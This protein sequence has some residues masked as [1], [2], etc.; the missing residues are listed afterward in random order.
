MKVSSI[1]V[2]CMILA[3]IM[4][5]ASANPTWSVDYDSG[6]E[7][8][9]FLDSLRK[10]LGVGPKVCNISVTNAARS[11]SYVLADLVFAGDVI[12]LAFRASN[13]Y[14]VGF[15]D[16]DS[17]TKK[18]RANFF[19]DE[20]SALSRNYKSIFKDAVDVS[21]L[22]CESSYI[23]LESKAGSRGTISLGVL[24]LQTAIKNV[25]GKDFNAKGENMGKI[26]AKFALISIQMISEAARFKYIEGQVKDRGMKKSFQL[27]GNIALLE[28]NWSS[29]S[30]QY[31]NKSRNCTP[32]DTRFTV[33]QMKLG[34]LLY[35][36]RSGLNSDD[37]HPALAFI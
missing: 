23:D 25:Y 9:S 16:K 36:T 6:M 19:S 5:A 34:L 14:L 1:S 33:D 26:V 11:S 32:Q 13:A 20:Y 29:L 15:Q 17:K 22:P 7:Y 3:V 31:H 24:S 8:L 37:G 2:W 27:G 12:T 10:D 35:K 21:K 4:A 30:N 28:N 18:I